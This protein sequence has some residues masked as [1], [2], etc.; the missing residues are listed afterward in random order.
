MIK[1]ALEYRRAFAA[2]KLQDTPYTCQLV[3]D[4]WD[5]A[6]SICNCLYVFLDA[7]MVVSGTLYPTAHMYFHEL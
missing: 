2:L 7:T 4:E 6:K 1:T 5:T 3:N